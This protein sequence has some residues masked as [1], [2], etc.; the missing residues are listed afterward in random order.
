MSD[1]LRINRFLAGPG[2]GRVRYWYP[3][4]AIND[5]GDRVTYVMETELFEDAFLGEQMF[6]VPRINI[7]REL[8]IRTDFDAEIF[9]D[10]P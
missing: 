10:V 4:A 5:N 1:R 2:F 7:E 8:D 6:I 9:I 3:I